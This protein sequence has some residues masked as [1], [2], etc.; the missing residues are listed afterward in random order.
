MNCHYFMFETCQNFDGISPRF[1][2]PN[3]R[4]NQQKRRALSPTPKTYITNNRIHI[5]TQL[6]LT[7]Y[8]QKC[9]HE[10]LSHP[11][12]GAQPM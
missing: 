3:H 10:D 11:N 12:L 7:Y 9:T 8:L 5:K 6:N 1:L 4:L 2:D